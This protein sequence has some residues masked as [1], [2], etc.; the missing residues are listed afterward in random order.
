G[1]GTAAVPNLA[2][3]PEP[4]ASVIRDA[5]AVATSSIFLYVLPFAVLSVLVVLFIRQVP[6]KTKTGLERLAEEN[7]TAETV[8][9]ELVD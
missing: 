5:Y 6:L 3:I 7:T 1:S 2:T 8:T 4:V 9:A